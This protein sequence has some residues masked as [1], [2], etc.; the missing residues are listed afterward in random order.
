MYVEILHMHSK[1]DLG[2]VA[3]GNKWLTFIGPCLLEAVTFGLLQRS[4]HFLKNGLQRGSI[5]TCQIQRR[6]MF[7]IADIEISAFRI[8]LPS[9]CLSKLARRLW[10]LLIHPLEPRDAAKTECLF[11]CV[12]FLNCCRAKKKKGGFFLLWSQK[13]SSLKFP[14]NSS[15]L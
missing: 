3:R 13:I 6:R 4:C 2:R 15:K 9:E 5:A 14:K 1:D 10:T 7:K 12:K 11:D 8:W